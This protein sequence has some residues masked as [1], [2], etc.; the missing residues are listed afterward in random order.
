MLHLIIELLQVELLVLYLNIGL[1][2]TIYSNA[3]F[4]WY[5]KLCIKSIKSLT[6][7]KYIFFFKINSPQNYVKAVDVFSL[8][9]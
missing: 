8:P 5:S 3:N 4:D 7:Q 2:C 9:I 1:Q 6:R